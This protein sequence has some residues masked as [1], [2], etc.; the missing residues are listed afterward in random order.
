MASKAGE[1]GMSS[2]ANWQGS[3][4]TPK[5]VGLAR[6]LLRD[7]ARRRMQPG[8]RLASEHEL[9]RH[10][11]MSRVTVRQALQL[12]E[13]DGYVSRQRARGT[14]VERQVDIVEHFG[15]LHGAVLVACSNAQGSRSDDDVAHSTVLRSMER[16][17][18]AHGF[19]VQILG[20]GEDVE[21]DRLRIQSLLVRGELEGIVSIGHC[22]D[23]HRDLLGDIP[24]VA[25][26]TF[27]VDR[28]PWV[29]NDVRLAAL[30]LTRHLLERGHEN[31]AMICGSWMDRE[32]FSRFAEGYRDAFEAAGATVDRAMMIH[33]HSTESLDE[34]TCS[35]LRSRIQPTAVICENWQVCRAA[36]RAAD[37]LE[38]R[39]PDDISVVGF[40]Q[41]VLEMA[42]TVELTAYVPANAQVGSEAAEVLIRMLRGEAPP[43]VP[44]CFPGRLII[45]ESVQDLT[46]ARSTA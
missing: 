2:L 27:T 10:H 39:I 15:L 37:S 24:L 43:Q 45:R 6:H 11:N 28:L 36:L 44:T 19:S 13:N 23:P 30:E 22:L 1:D 9:V 3:W 46:G 42:S 8:D 7:I 38:L 26:C 41:N 40:G 17:F 31:I 33:A 20:L 32:G 34:L 4:S 5:Y 29:G 35:V 14:F 21:K 16:T 12:L 25:S 18:A